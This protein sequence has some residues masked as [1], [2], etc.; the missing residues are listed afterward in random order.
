MAFVGSPTKVTHRKHHDPFLSGYLF[1]ASLT[2]RYHRNVARIS[3]RI[4]RPDGRRRGQMRRPRGVA[5]LRA[6]RAGGYPAAAR[7]CRKILTTSA[8]TKWFGL[9]FSYARPSLRR[10][11]CG[12]IIKSG[13]KM[14]RLVRACLSLCRRAEESPAQSHGSLRSNCR[15]TFWRN[16]ILILQARSAERRSL[17]CWTSAQSR[18]Q[19][20]T[21]EHRES[22]GPAESTNYPSDRLES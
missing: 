14:G 7:G 1:F 3:L 10:W 20:R 8:I 13:Y 4:A 15:S 2:R 17:P 12:S 5:F 16:Q 18:S 11:F 21:R 22:L 6:Q 9:N 19:T